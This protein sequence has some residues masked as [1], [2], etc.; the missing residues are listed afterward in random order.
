MENKKKGP[1]LGLI[2]KAA[3]KAAQK[4]A[5]RKGKRKAKLQHKHGGTWEKVPKERRVTSFPTRET[6]W[7]DYHK[8]RK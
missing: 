1:I 3:Q 2:K 6:E 7:V 5:V 8:T 4:R